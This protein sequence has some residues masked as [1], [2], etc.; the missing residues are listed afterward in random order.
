MLANRNYITFIESKSHSVDLCSVISICDY[1]ITG[2][3]NI[4]NVLNTYQHLKYN[5]SIDNNKNYTNLKYPAIYIY[6]IYSL[7]SKINSFVIRYFQCCYVIKF[8]IYSSYV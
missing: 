2:F 6:N 5:I 4:L 7:P 3:K 8:N 1:K